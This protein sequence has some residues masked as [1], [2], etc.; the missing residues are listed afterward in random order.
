MLAL[1]SCAPYKGLHTMDLHGGTKWPTPYFTRNIPTSTDQ[2]Q[3][4]KI[5]HDTHGSIT[6]CTDQPQHARI[7]HDTHKSPTTLTDQ[8]KRARISHKLKDQSQHSRINREMHRSVTT[9]S[10]LNSQSSFY[11][12]GNSLSTLGSSL[13]DQVS[14]SHDSAVYPR[15]DR[16]ITVFLKD[17]HII[18]LCIPQNGRISKPVLSNIKFKGDTS[19]RIR[20]WQ[21]A[22]TGK[23]Q[24]RQGCQI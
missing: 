21:Q 17:D 13:H 7:S 10:D 20:K 16:D 24:H 9:L 1:Q 22:N 15:D 11:M 6:T 5:N 12:H 18:T 19:L 8:S 14:E 23:Y 3:H 2:S 4:L